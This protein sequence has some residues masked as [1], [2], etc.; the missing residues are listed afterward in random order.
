MTAQAYTHVI[1]CSFTL[2]FN[3]TYLRKQCISDIR[4]NPGRRLLLFL[5]YTLRRAIKN[6]DI[7][8]ALCINVSANMQ[9]YFYELIK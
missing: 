3:L 6:N 2:F 4:E 7:V 9:L 5:N 1:A 8:N